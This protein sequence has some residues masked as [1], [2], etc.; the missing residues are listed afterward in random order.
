MNNADFNV[1]SS[2][3][4]RINIPSPPAQ[5]FQILENQ[6]IYFIRV[7]VG[8][9]VRRDY[10]VRYIP[11]PSHPYLFKILY[12]RN[13][14]NDDSEPYKPWFKYGIPIPNS[15]PFEDFPENYDFKIFDNGYENTQIFDLGEA[16]Q[17][18]SEF[19]TPDEVANIPEAEAEFVNDS[20]AVAEA[21]PI[22]TLLP[23]TYIHDRR[24]SLPKISLSNERARSL[25]AYTDDLMKP[26]ISQ[27][28]NR[29][30]KLK[31]KK[32]RKYKYKK[33]RKSRKSKS[34][35]SKSRKSRKSRK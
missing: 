7:N 28:M 25:G 9:K 21:I 20:G 13:R 15:S 16:G 18:I 22:A 5:L 4:Q 12:K 3:W 2:N 35:K 32:S 30:G 1:S 8:M 23:R 26:T 34:R 24:E 6:R 33:S 31:Y 14:R 29:G 11:T 27:K 10:I 19:V 17:Q